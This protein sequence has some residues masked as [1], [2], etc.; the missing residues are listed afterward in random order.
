M[1]LLS[2][3]RRQLEYPRIKDYYGNV[4]FKEDVYLDGIDIFADIMSIISQV[5]VYLK[6]AIDNG[7]NLIFPII[8]LYDSKD[9]NSTV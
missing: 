9:L 5:K 6:I 2:W 4:E 1:N 8:P 3:K 7:T